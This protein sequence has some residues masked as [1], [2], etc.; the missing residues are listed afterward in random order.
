MATPQG[1]A[2]T[3][4]WACLPSAL[5]VWDTAP[6]CMAWRGLPL[7]GNGGV[8]GGGCA[9]WWWMGVARW[10]SGCSSCAAS[11]VPWLPG[12]D[13][14]RPPARPG[15]PASQLQGRRRHACTRATQHLALGWPARMRLRSCPPVP[16]LQQHEGALPAGLPAPAHPASHAGNWQKGAHTQLAASHLASTPTAHTL[17]LL[18]LPLP[19]AGSRPCDGPRSCLGVAL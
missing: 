8:R 18:P 3:S 10:Q 17:P 13:G 16:P 9:W 6:P 19:P 15:P 2:G 7:R 14:H 4:G 5:C 12:R 1:R 11:I